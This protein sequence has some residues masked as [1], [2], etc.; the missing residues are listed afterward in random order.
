MF[1]KVALYLIS[2]ISPVMLMNKLCSIWP[3]HRTYYTVVSRSHFVNVPMNWKLSS[4]SIAIKFGYTVVVFFFSFLM[5]SLSHSF[6]FSIHITR[7]NLNLASA[8]FYVNANN[9]IRFFFYSFLCSYTDNGTRITNTHKKENNQWMNRIAKFW[10]QI[11]CINRIAITF[12]HSN[13]NLLIALLFGCEQ[14]K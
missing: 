2:I 12:A 1:H 4:L 8:V 14:I 5:Y 6:S 9:K 7:D 10:N 11:T 3:T 13:Y